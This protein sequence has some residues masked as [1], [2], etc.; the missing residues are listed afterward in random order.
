MQKRA[1]RPLDKESL[2]LPNVRAFEKM[3]LGSSTPVG[4]A[5]G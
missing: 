3:H 2:F 4:A 1:K 5:S